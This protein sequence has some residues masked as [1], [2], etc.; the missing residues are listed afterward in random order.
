MEPM[1]DGA[2]RLWEG[3][4]DYY[5]AKGSSKNLGGASGALE[6]VVEGV[7]KGKSVLLMVE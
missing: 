7:V 1:S 4:K 2:N 5:A 3:A 6:E